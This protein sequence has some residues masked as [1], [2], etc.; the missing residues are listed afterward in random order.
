MEPKLQMIKAQLKVN[1]HRINE[2]HRKVA[3]CKIEI[4]LNN[5]E[6]SALIRAK[7]EAQTECAKTISL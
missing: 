1:N 4:N 2:L 6:M 3:N 5:R 7:A